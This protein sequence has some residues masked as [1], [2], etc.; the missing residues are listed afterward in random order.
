M[1]VHATL[2]KLVPAGSPSNVKIVAKRSA[3]EVDELLL[4]DLAK[5]HP[6]PPQSRAN[7]AKACIEYTISL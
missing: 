2:T 4:K 7:T 3:A 5:V 1:L 6:L